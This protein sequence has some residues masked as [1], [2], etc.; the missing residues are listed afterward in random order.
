MNTRIKLLRTGVYAIK[1]VEN[2]TKLCKI[3]SDEDLK[4]RKYPKAS[5]P[6]EYFFKVEYAG[7]EIRQA[8]TVKPDSL[9]AYGKRQLASGKLSLADK[10]EIKWAKEEIDD[11]NEDHSVFVDPSIAKKYDEMYFVD[12]SN[13]WPQFFVVSKIKR[14]AA[15]EHLDHCDEYLGNLNAKAIIPPG[16]DGLVFAEWSY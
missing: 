5:F 13:A 2:V 10:E 11:W 14:L 4:T 1:L 8:E 12:P 15:G 3:V 16:Y 7:L 9:S 6:R